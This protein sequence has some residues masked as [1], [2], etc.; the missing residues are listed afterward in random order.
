MITSL[1]RLVQRLGQLPRQN[2]VKIFITIVLAGILLSTVGYVTWLVYIKPQTQTF[3][4]INLTRKELVVEVLGYKKRINMFDTYHY[5]TQAKG[6]VDVK[7]YDTA[8]NLLETRTK[9]LGDQSGIVLD[10]LTETEQQAQCVISSDATT[11][12]YKATVRIDSAV[13]SNI[14]GISIVGPNPQKEFYFNTTNFRRNYVYPDTYSGAFLPN[15]I[16]AYT[17]VIGYYPVPCADLA[18]Q[19]KLKGWVT[20]WQNYSAENQR[21]LYL[22]EVEKINET[23]QF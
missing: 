7:I 18:D 21:E 8:E 16:D 20:W 3:T 23:T 22:A 17:R 5:V 12:Y 10:L 2:K 14:F 13:P 4:G 11:N 6:Q 9:Q 15:E 19:N 1:K